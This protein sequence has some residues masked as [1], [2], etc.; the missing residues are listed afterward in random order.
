MD[1]VAG[2]AD[3]RA[4]AEARFRVVGRLDWLR[5]GRR[6]LLGPELHA[7]ARRYSV[8]PLEV[9]RP[10]LAQDLHCWQPLQVFGRLRLVQLVEQREPVLT[11][12]ARVGLG[13]GR[14]P[15]QATVLNPAHVAPVP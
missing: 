14:R 15:R 1:D 10:D 5:R 11:D 2:P 4:G 9:A 12:G 6:L 13:F 8:L 3:A 7:A